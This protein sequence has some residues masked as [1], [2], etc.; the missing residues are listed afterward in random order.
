[1]ADMERV[2]CAQKFILDR[3]APST[4]RRRILHP[5]TVIREQS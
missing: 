5:G 3:R 1:M 4:R 2:V